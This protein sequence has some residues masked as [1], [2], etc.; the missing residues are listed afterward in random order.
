MDMNLIAAE[1]CKIETR[2]GAITP[3]AVVK[4]AQ[5]KNHPL[6]EHFDWNNNTAGHNWRLQQARQLINSVKVVIEIEDREIRSIAYVR[7]PAVDGDEQGYRRITRLAE[8]GDAHE[9]VL[10]EF[11]RAE[12]HLQ[13]AYSVAI[14]LDFASDIDGLIERL[15]KLAAKVRGKAERQMAEAAE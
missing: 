13:R 7:D 2:S 4:A 9:A 15:G 3:V 6:H 12:S 14:V 8:T 10:A 11:G 1:L 5:V